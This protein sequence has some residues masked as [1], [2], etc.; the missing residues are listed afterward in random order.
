MNSL[1]RLRR[2]LKLPK[3]QVS[4]W[5]DQEFEP[6]KQETRERIAMEIAARFTTPNIFVM[7]S[8]EALCAK[9][10]NR[11][12]PG[13]VFYG[14]DYYR[15][16]F[17]KV[18]AVDDHGKTINM[19]HGSVVEYIE[20]NAGNLE[21]DA[22]FLDYKTNYAQVRQQMQRFAVRMMK[23]TAVFAITAQRGELQDVALLM[24]QDVASV[25]ASVELV[26]SIE[27]KTT[28]PMVNAIF[29]L[30]KDKAHAEDHR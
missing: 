12:V 5:A 1:R 11:L 23:S 6:Q 3:R 16:V 4:A 29:V 28:L 22:A 21:F 26:H 2:P 19:Q 17:E 10:I 7:P 24:Q 25:I 18:D 8:Y 30:H 9:T 15:S 20:E 14:T 13:A 27:Y